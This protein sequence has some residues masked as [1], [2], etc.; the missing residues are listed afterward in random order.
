MID[1]IVEI[2]KVY[3]GI[4]AMLILIDVISFLLA[5]WQV[6]LAITFILALLIALFLLVLPIIILVKI[7]K[8]IF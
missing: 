4:V 5:H 2:T 7:V 3:L 8:F 1:V 6:V